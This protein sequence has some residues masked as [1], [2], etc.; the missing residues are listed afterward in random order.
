VHGKR[1][2]FAGLRV[3][4]AEVVSY[5][6]MSLEIESGEYPFLLFSLVLVFFF[7]MSQCDQID[8]SVLQREWS[9]Q[10]LSCATSMPYVP[11][12]RTN[13]MLRASHNNR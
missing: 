1:R 8:A 9:L 11:L 13:L 4:L 7:L 6:K 12:E 10:H 5:L 2:A 3:I